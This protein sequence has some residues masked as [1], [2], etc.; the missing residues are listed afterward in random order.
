MTVDNHRI[1]A[2]A[3]LARSECDF[4]ELCEQGANEE[5]IETAE[6]MMFERDEEFRD[7]IYL[8]QLND[9]L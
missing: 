6:R 5:D 2:E 8:F 7:A 3:E 4:L 9:S 1:L